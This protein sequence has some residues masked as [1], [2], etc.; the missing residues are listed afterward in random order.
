MLFKAQS[1]CR[2][3]AFPF[4]RFGSTINL[5][6]CWHA[7]M[8]GRRCGTAGQ[9]RAT[10]FTTVGKMGGQGSA[11]KN[12]LCWPWPPE[13]SLW[14]NQLL[15]GLLWPPRAWHGAFMHTEWGWGGLE[16]CVNGDVLTVRTWGLA[17][18]SPARMEKS[19]GCGSSVISA[20]GSRRQIQG[21][22]CYLNYLNRQVW[23]HWESLPQ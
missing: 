2:L 17:F 10:Y 18:E 14:Q 23:V 19:N 12:A 11:G 20:L 6:L 1:T 4:Q 15:K 8:G 3:L 21:Q 13:F 22:T 5:V 9:S 16:S 7:L